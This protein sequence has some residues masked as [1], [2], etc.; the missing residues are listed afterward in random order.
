[1]FRPSACVNEKQI[2]VFVR[3]AAGRGRRTI[4]YKVNDLQLC[5][6]I[7]KPLLGPLPFTVSATIAFG[8]YRELHQIV[9]IG[10][11]DFLTLKVSV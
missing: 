6:L 3:L 9:C 11:G 7:V 1:M 10:P 8:L 4:V 2:V 5:I